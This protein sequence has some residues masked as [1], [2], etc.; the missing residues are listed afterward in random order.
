MNDIDFPLDTVLSCDITDL[1]LSITG[2]PE[3]FGV[4]IEN[5]NSCDLSVTYVDDTTSICNDI[6]YQIQRTWTVMESCTGVMAT[7]L[8]IISVVDT[9]A[10]VITCPGPYN[11]FY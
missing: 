10:P 7:D 6:E 2:Q 1:N 3:L 11:Y 8:Q 9:V 4:I 5:T